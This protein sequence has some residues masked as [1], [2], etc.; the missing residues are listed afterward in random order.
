MYADRIFLFSFFFLIISKKFSNICYRK[1]VGGESGKGVKY[2]RRK[3]ENHSTFPV[4]IY[5]MKRI[6]SQENMIESIKP[7]MQPISQQPIMQPIS[8]QPIMQPISQQLMKPITHNLPVTFSPTVRETIITKAYLSTAMTAMVDEMSIDIPFNIANSFESGKNM[9]D[10]INNN[11]FTNLE[12]LLLWLSIGALSSGFTLF[13]RN[14]EH[15]YERF[16]NFISYRDIR[17]QMNY[18]LLVLFCIFVRNIPP[19]M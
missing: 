6:P 8:Q 12:N 17:K 15:V 16:G 13:E 5:N 3:I 11:N 10:D 19:V 2:K 1:I 7:I 18:G 4:N 14:K 9:I